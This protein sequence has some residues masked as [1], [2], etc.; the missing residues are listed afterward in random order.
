MAGFRFG[1]VVSSLLLAATLLRP[2]A[3]RADDVT[4]LA[5]LLSSSSEKQRLSAV[6]SLAR[7]GDKR[8]LK[9]L[10]AA[11]HDPD[12]KI[13][14]IAATALGHLGH[15]AALPELRAAADDPD[16]LVRTHARAAAIAVAKAN[17]LPANL[18]AAPAPDP[19]P[20]AVEAR[21]VAGH[22]RPGF[23]HQ[24]HAVE[25]HPD[26]YVQIKSSSDDAPGK[27][28]KAARKIHADLIRQV[29]FDQFKATS[30]VTTVAADAARWGLDSRH[31]DLSVVRMEVVQSGTYVEIVAELRLAISD[32]TGKMLSFL[33]G[34]AKVQIPKRTF[35]PRYLPDLRKEAL[36]NAMRGMFD[37]LLA[38]LRGAT[39]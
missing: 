3:A 10:V 1:R 37:K 31:I 28:D 13:R 18:P 33:S 7:L 8:T 39:S 15:K 2:V 14:A 29:L 26:L 20:S 30:T 16:D 12:A 19:G 38:H 5:K 21:H 17:H 11:L 36:E 6:I 34:G 23:G 24:G 32:D 22:G 35:D 9:P 4:E 25:A 27:Y